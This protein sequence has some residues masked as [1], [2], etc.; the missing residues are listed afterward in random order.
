LGR[1]IGLEGTADDVAAGFVATEGAVYTGLVE[2]LRANF[3]FA[4]GGLPTNALP[5]GYRVAA[6]GLAANAAVCCAFFC[7]ELLYK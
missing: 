7:F 4:G 5:L 6:R 2:N 3:F 1:L